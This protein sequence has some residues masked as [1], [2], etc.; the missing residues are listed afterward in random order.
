MH[1]Y[2]VIKKDDES[3]DVLLYGSLLSFELLY[4]ATFHR[5]RSYS[6]REPLRCNTLY[7]QDK[8]LYSRR[9]QLG[10]DILRRIFFVNWVISIYRIYTKRKCYVSCIL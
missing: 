7:Q 8:D 5:W 10:E 3:Y 9:T 4:E 2:N 1:D 6:Q